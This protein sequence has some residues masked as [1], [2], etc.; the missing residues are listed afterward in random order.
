[1]EG[2]KKT[3]AE[4][5][6]RMH[7]AGTWKVAQPS[8]EL[9]AW[10]YNLAILHSLALLEIQGDRKNIRGGLVTSLANTEHKDSWPS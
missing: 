5:A 1:M 10:A 6:F 2:G 4:D 8:W 3:E 9:S 7:R